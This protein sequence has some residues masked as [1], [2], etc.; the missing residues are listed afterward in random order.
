M[1]QLVDMNKTELGWLAKHLGHNLEVDK[2]YYRL[3][4][5]TL[6]IA[7]VGNLLMAVD[8]GETNKFAGKSLRDISLNG[9]ISM[10]GIV[11]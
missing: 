10:H 5:H 3:Q 11:M 1:S 7:V 9:K 6:E 2:D 4:E 8:N